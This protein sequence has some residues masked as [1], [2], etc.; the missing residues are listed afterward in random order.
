MDDLVEIIF[1]KDEI[2]LFLNFIEVFKKYDPDFILGYETEVNSI[3]SIVRR[4]EFLKIKMKQHI[5]RIN[6]SHLNSFNVI[7]FFILKEDYY[8]SHLKKGTFET[9]KSIQDDSV[10]YKYL[11]QKFG[12]RVKV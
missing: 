10:E 12:K 4:A 3:A 6:Y 2:L 9:N 5:S 1:V 7:Q 8:R 11:E